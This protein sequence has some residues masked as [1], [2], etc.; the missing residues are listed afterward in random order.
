VAWEQL[1][2]RTTPA[3]G[4][5]DQFDCAS[6]GSQEP[7]QAELDRDPSGPSNLDPDDGT[8]SDAGNQYRQDLF[9]SGGSAS[10]PVPLMTDGGCP[11]Q[12][13]AERDGACYPG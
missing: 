1:T 7:A 5:T 3:I 10:G 6:F 11:S 9:D 13:P 8:T 4:Q 12:F 2:D